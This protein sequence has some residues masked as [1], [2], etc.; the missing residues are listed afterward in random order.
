MTTF[1]DMAR[2]WLEYTHLRAAGLSLQDEDVASLA[3]LIRERED[4]A[5]ERAADLCWAYSVERDG[6]CSKN[7]AKGFVN[8]AHDDGVASRTAELLCNRIR[9]LKHKG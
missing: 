6:K 2:E 9:A 4:A 3:T 7:F 1:E 8:S 5:I